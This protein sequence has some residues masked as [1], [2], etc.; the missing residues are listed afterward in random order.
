MVWK[1]ISCNDKNLIEKI[2]AIPSPILRQQVRCLIESLPLC[3]W[4]CAPIIGRIARVQQIDAVVYDD[5]VYDFALT[6][7]HLFY[8]GSAFW[9]RTVRTGISGTSSTTA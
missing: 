1:S 2:T 5:Y 3:D 7:I 9:S 6:D 8:A 4:D